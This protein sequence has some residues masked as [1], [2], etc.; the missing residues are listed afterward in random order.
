MHGHERITKHR[1]MIMEFLIRQDFELLEMD[2]IMIHCLIDA[3]SDLTKQY[4]S[5]KKLQHT[6]FS[7]LSVLQRNFEKVNPQHYPFL[8]DLLTDDLTN[9]VTYLRFAR[10]LQSY[11]DR[12]FR[13][14]VSGN[15]LK[16]GIKKMI[17][18]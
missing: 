15:N 4:G 1:R 7:F 14:V 8:V 6:T 3:Y 17:D 5:R 2:S 9:K 10:T 12:I 13:E 18:S 11:L 16:P